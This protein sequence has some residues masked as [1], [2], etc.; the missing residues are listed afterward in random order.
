M[1]IV[2]AVL[3]I[4]KIFL[5]SHYIMNY[6]I[7]CCI[8]GHTLLMKN[9][10]GHFF[11]R[12]HSAGFSQKVFLFFAASFGGYLWEIAVTYIWNGIICNRGFLHGPW[13]PTYGF[14]ALFLLLLLK[15]FSFHPM[16]VFFLSDYAISLIYPNAGAGITF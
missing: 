14:G 12:I 15:R 4:V 1:A 2:S 7:I 13:L 5:H 3:Q 9:K 10:I 11:S 8:I 16:R 6:I